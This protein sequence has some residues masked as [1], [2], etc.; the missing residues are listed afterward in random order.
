[1]RLVNFF[2]LANAPSFGNSLS[3]AVNPRPTHPFFRDSCIIMEERCPRAKLAFHLFRRHTFSLRG[4]RCRMSSAFRWLLIKEW[5]ELIVSRAW[6]LLLL[7]MGPLVGVSFISAMHIYAEVSGLNG[8]AAGVG[9]ALSPLIGV[10]APTFSACELAAVFLLPFVAIRIVAGDRQSG[11]L[12]L[13]LQRGMSP[14]VRIAAKAIVA[15]GGWLIAMLPPLS[16]ILLW[17]S[18]GG[19]THPP[20]LATL[21]GGHILN[22]GLTIALGAAAASVTEHPSTAAILTLS[23][24]VGTWIVNFFAAV[25]GGFWERVATYP[26][27][28]IV[29]DFQHG[30]VRLDTLLIATLLTLAGLSVAAV[31]QVLGKPEA[32]RAYESAGLILIATL[33][34]AACSSARAT[35]DTSENRAN[36]FPVADERALRQIH[37]PLKIVAHLAPED[38]R[39]SDLEHRALAKLRRILPNL[40]VEY[41]S[42]TS[43]GLFEQTS[44][45]YGEIRYSI[46]N[47]S[48]TSRVTTAEGVL[49]TIYALAG[50]TPP[51]DA[52]EPVFRGHPLAVR[53]SGAP[54]IFYGVWPGLTLLAGFLVRRRFK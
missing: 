48:A 27:A 15:L 9:E 32:R 47:R 51:S 11:A 30:L 14:F 6:W 26:P 25:Q 24:T 35:W 3:P 53:S 4:V 23:V 36:S 5:R 12:K 46:G 49:E 37:E 1:M 50:V 52:D 21:I 8:T 22:A 18:Y 34:I 7:L 29:A 38:P 28:A 39:R 10:W 41:V 31:W 42:A 40:E 20:E 17:K 54:A 45:G 44:A 13:E 33:A 43:I 2:I 19:I 16:A